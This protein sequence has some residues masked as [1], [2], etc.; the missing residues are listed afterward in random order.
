MKQ[1]ITLLAATALFA[2]CSKQ[3]LQ[4]E[5]VQQDSA[6]RSSATRNSVEGAYVSGWEQNTQWQKSDQSGMSIFT[7]Q[8]KTPEI[9]SSVLD[10]GLVLTYG[11]ANTN[12]PRYAHLREPQMMPFFFLPESERVN[13]YYYHFSEEV[14]NGSINIIF[15]M[16]FTK[17]MN[18]QI[19]GGVTLNDVQYQH[20]VL[21][22]SFLESR[23]LTASTVR[24]YYTY[25]QVMDLVNPL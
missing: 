5:S 12:D 9:N 6:V 13:G 15:R 22:R 18:P 23:G 16:P 19:G 1:W 24:N 21:T 4:E 20:V 2:S 7:L 25:N 17:E 11:K 8:R 14:S 10:G 3:D